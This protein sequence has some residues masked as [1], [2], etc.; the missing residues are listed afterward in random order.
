MSA[1]QRLFSLQEQYPGRCGVGDPD[2]EQ[3]PGARLPPPRGSRRQ[4]P[5]TG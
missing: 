4:P 1:L 5:P 2:P 3:Q